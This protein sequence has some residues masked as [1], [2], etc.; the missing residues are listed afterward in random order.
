MEGCGDSEED[1]AES[2][3]I[4]PNAE[5]HCTR[6]LR[7]SKNPRDQRTYKFCQKN[8][9]CILLLPCQ[10]LCLWIDCDIVVDSYPVCYSMKSVS[11]EFYMS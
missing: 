4:D 1:D 10:H 8:S 2:S 7:G 11:V 5:V 6:S 9:V 3:H